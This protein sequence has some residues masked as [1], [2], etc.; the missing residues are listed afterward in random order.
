MTEILINVLIFVESHW[1]HSSMAFH[2][3]NMNL[4]HVSEDLLPKLVTS[5]LCSKGP[6][7]TS[8]FLSNYAVVIA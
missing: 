3:R 8:K 4:I 5:I 1:K 7:R 6:L 2:K